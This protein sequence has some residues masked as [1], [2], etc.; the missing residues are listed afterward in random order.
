[1]AAPVFKELAEYIY[2]KM[3]RQKVLAMPENL[4]VKN[5]DKIL[6]KYKTVMPDVR[7][8]SAKDALFV[9]ENMGLKVIMK[10]SG[11]VKKQS[12]PRGERI[13]KKQI[14]ELQLS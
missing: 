9:L 3:P 11:I 14:I 6:E 5:L 8:L 10:G 4:P 12:V 2:G 7:G 13:K 1:M